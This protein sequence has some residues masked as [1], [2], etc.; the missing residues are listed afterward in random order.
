MVQLADEIYQI[1][2]LRENEK[3]AAPW[4]LKTMHIDN[5]KTPFWLSWF[6]NPML[7]FH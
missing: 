1:A 3:V 7:L 6:S 2:D 5:I 4:P